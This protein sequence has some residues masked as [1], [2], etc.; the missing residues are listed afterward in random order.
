[1][2]LYRSAYQHWN[3]EYQG[4]WYRRY[5]IAANGIQ[6]AWASKWTRNMVMAAWILS[7]VQA[8]LL[9]GIGQLLVEDSVI[10]TLVDQLGP[11]LQV[12]TMA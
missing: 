3:G 1:M 8:A 12:F 5:A 2:S 9:F 6:S 11:Q 4:I 10:Y 7:I